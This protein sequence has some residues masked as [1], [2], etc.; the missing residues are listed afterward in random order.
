M[1]IRVKGY[2]DGVKDYL[3]NGQKEGRFHS[4]DELDERVPLSGDLNFVN[5]IIQSMPSTD[6]D[7]Y[8]NFTL[9]FKEDY[10]D[11]KTLKNAVDELMSYYFSAY[12]LDEMCHYAEAHLPKIKSYNDAKNNL[13]ERKPHIHIVV[14][15][16][17]LLTGERI[18]YN[19]KIT[20]KYRDA[21]QEYFNFKY[22]FE[23][24]KENKRYKVNE[25]SEY[26]SRY[27]GDG[28]IGASKLF[29]QDLLNKIIENNI[30]NKSELQLLLEENGKVKVRNSTDKDKAYFN[31]MIGDKSIN[32][33]D[34]VFKESFLS[35]TK[36]EKLKYI[37]NESNVNLTN[38]YL[39]QKINGEVPT[40]YTN[41]M[42]EWISKENLYWRHAKNF[43]SKEHEKYKKLTTQEQ[44]ILLQDKHNKIIYKD[45]DLNIK[46]EI[47]KDEYRR[48]TANNINSIKQCNGEIKGNTSRTTSI[49]GASDRLDQRGRRR[50]KQRITRYSGSDWGSERGY[51]S[52]HT[53][54]TRLSN[55][56][57]T[58]HYKKISEQEFLNKT[59]K[60]H[61][62]KPTKFIT[63]VEEFN[64]NIEANVL[65]ELLEKT[66]GVNPEIYRITLNKNGDDRIGAGS[67]N[68]SIFDFCR[69]E[70]NLSWQQTIDILIKAQDLQNTINRDKTYSRGNRKY[71]WSEYQL[72]LKQFSQKPFNFSEFSVKRKDINQR[73]K[74]QLYLLNKNKLITTQD[75]LNLTQSIKFAKELEL[76][77]LKDSISKFKI[78]SRH[79]FNKNMQDSY[80][81]FLL[82]Q[83]KKNDSIALA[84]L[85]RLRIDYAQ[86]QDSLIIAYVQR[87][88]DYKLNLSHE[89]DKNGIISYKVD[90]NIVLKDH[91]QW[92]ESIRTNEGNIKLAIDLS[93]KKFGN[94]LCLRGKES[95]RDK[96]I[97]YVIKNGINIEFTDSYSK[98][99][100]ATKLS[101]LIA[102]NVA[103]EQSKT[104]LIEDK[105]LKLKINNIHQSKQL[106][107]NKLIDTTIVEVVDIDT[108]KTYQLSGNFLHF[109]AKSLK[110]DDL[111]NAIVNNETGDVNLVLKPEYELKKQIKAEAL[112]KIQDNFRNE[113]NTAETLLG[114]YLGSGVNKSGSTWVL[115]KSNDGKLS[116][117]TNNSIYL[118][119]KSSRKYDPVLIAKLPDIKR[120]KPM[121]DR[122]YVLSVKPN[123]LTD[124]IKS[125][126]F[127][128]NLVTGLVLKQT[129]FM[130]PS[131]RPGYRILLKNIH[132][133]K[134][135][136]LFTKASGK[137]T[138]G[139]FIQF[140]HDGEW[141]A[142][143]EMKQLNQFKTSQLKDATVGVLASTETIKIRGKNVFCASFTTID[144]TVKKY[145]EKLKNAITFNQVKLGDN[146]ELKQVLTTKNIEYTEEA[147]IVK[148]LSTELELQTSA[149]LQR[150]IR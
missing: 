133:N 140:K 44:L 79:Q 75:K 69:R 50:L 141:S 147:Y 66:H 17:N 78:Q 74:K 11:I 34:N 9:S 144:G 150:I 43:S 92:V 18:S 2:S 76:N 25:N 112:N 58:Y 83:A 21:F 19:E 24:P 55:S 124:I 7:K 35:L 115:I 4:R 103:L 27:K 6:G 12:K 137:F 86:Y 122:D 68:L 127:N 47:L 30:S 49:D 52:N 14:P 54:I 15:R 65:L 3:E 106:I 32:L 61:L 42:N 111:V 53:G 110:K 62:N 31:V 128:K 91:G 107:T 20:E 101:E 57:I 146:C 108:M 87:F 29:R 136:V 130:Y 145:G 149:A 41:L 60:L 104:T 67:R 51:Q 121:N 105:P 23:S 84:E 71:L 89:I 142:V 148:N 138:N 99:I 33:R 94:K 16:I 63:L 125:I 139:Q 119:L 13:V 135:E 90:N 100:H 28:F 114:K 120:L 143:K 59:Q 134:M 131:G 132:T 88:D 46:S 45:N 95:F 113:N 10:V 85:R 98:N 40:K 123:E 96:V 48:I 82:E 116:K 22:G 77:H 129:T 5:N 73:F 36:E 39:E 97:D 8:T 118:Q 64:K 81:K 38:Q 72:W 109:K 56:E 117:Y 80:R 126:P 1:L 26:I 93:T 102:I 37:K 70:M